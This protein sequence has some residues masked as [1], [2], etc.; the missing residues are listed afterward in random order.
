M[1]YETDK[2]LTWYIPEYQRIAGILGPAARVCEIGVLRGLGLIM[3]QDLFPQGLVA[4]VNANPGSH[5]PDGTVRIVASQ[6]D[7]A[8]P[9]L[10][11]EHAPAWDLIVDDAS[12]R[13]PQTQ[14]SFGLLWP[15]IAPGGFYVIEDWFI[16][17]PQFA[18]TGGAVAPMYDP[19]MLQVVQG[20]LTLLDE[21]YPGSEPYF[22]MP[23]S[24]DVESV[25]CQYGLAVVRKAVPGA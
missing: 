14:A 2:E 22:S 8:L 7:L 10:L 11:S 18:A 13:G 9:A 16:G 17:L 21:P 15:L 23:R 1:T 5:W 25:Y 12:H 19:G 24:R 3:F 6:D 4:G 20:L